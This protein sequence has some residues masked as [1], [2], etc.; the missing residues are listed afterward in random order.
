MFSTCFGFTAEG[1]TPL[2][3]TPGDASGGAPS[4]PKDA[5]STRGVRRLLTLWMVN[6]R[7]SVT[8]TTGDAD[9]RC[10]APFN[11]SREG[12]QR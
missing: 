3:F 6:D 12:S 10:P 9:V 7:I 11:L 1:K 2:S 8:N 4:Q 5:S